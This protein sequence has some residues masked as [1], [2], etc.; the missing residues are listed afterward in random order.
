MAIVLL[1]SG[2]AVPSANLSS[3]SALQSVDW[4]QWRQAAAIPERTPF[5]LS[6][7][8]E[9][10]VDLN[11]FFL[12]GEM[13]GRAWNTQDGYA[14]D[15][16]AFLNFL[17]RN[18]NRTTWRDVTA[19]DHLAYLVWRRTDPDGPRIDDS[20]WDREVT[21][22]NQ[23][24]AW[25]VR[26]QHVPGNSIPQPQI[27]PRPAPTRHGR[28]HGPRRGPATAPLWRASSV[29]CRRTSWTGAAGTLASNC[30]SRS[31]PGSSGPITAADAK[32]R[33]AG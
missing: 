5:L 30:G 1:S 21:A 22:V 2:V 16:K 32:L 29:C 28:L 18:R 9:Y 7:T 14:R 3:L 24:H 10:D 33:S 13:L 23:F 31:S 19:D 20:T 25:Q 4:T 12:S 15:L 11:G 17:W 8:F 6:P 26:A 27:R